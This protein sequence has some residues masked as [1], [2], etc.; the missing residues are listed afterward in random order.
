MEEKKLNFN[1]GF[2]FGL[3][4][5]TAGLV[6]YIIMLVITLLLVGGMMGGF[7]SMMH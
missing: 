4:F 3:G 5:F 1:D 2:W 7:G 6:F